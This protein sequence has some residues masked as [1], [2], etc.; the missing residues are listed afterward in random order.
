VLQV[1]VHD[2]QPVAAGPAE[3]FKHRAG[4][5]AVAVAGLTVDHID[6]EADAGPEVGDGRRGV[7]LAVVD[8][9]HFAEDSDWE[10]FEAYEQLRDVAGLV[11]GRNNQRDG[12]HVP[13]DRRS[14]SPD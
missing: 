12:S 8:E 7:V 13:G 1:G 9:D 10:P 11:A 14:R 3:A 6:G 5:A 2:G 4:Q